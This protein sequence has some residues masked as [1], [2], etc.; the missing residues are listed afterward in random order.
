MTWT[1]IGPR[2]SVIDGAS[3][4]GIHL[5]PLLPLQKHGLYLLVEELSC[6]GIPGIQPVVIDEDSLMLKPICP[7]ILAN[8]LVDPLPGL[9]PERWLL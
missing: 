3:F 8:L 9:V 2:G 1:M 6:L 7:A 4:G 5:L